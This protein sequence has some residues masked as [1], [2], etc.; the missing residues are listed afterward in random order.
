MLQLKSTEERKMRK[1]RDLGESVPEKLEVEV[2][3]SKQLIG[4]YG[5]KAVEAQLLRQ[6]WVTA[7]INTSIKNAAEFDIY[8]R[9]NQRRVNLRVKTCG[10]AE[11]GFTFGFRPGAKI[12]TSGFGKD[13]FTIL[14]RMGVTRQG[15]DYYVVPTAIVRKV[16]IAL[17]AHYLGQRKRDGTERVDTGDIRLRFRE[18]RGNDPG[19]GI[20]RKWKR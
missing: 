10:P 12:Q 14:V 2:E 8:A 4:A 20:D 18:S 1:S 7:N 16:L 15:D 5:E 11:S 17:R 6:G 9:K 13:D 3:L 19:S